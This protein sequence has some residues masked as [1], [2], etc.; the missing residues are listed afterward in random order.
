MYIKL[1]RKTPYFT[2]MTM[3][4]SPQTNQQQLP[5]SKQQ[6]LPSLAT[7]PYPSPNY[8]SRHPSPHV[9]PQQ[10]RTGHTSGVPSSA[11]VTPGVRGPSGI[12]NTAN[13]GTKHVAQRPGNLPISQVV[14]ISNL[15]YRL[16]SLIYTTI[17]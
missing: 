14:V 12:I 3:P 15:Y 13:N 6:S 10:P 11:G 9:N 4:A 2:G 5:S 7:P 1:I 8:S 17:I 16:K